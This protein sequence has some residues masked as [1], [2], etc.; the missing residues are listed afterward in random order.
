[1]IH[2]WLL[3]QKNSNQENK[4]FFRLKTAGILTIRKNY[5]K[6][7]ILVIDIHTNPKY[8]ILCYL[9]FLRVGI[10][11]VI[12]LQC[13]SRIYNNNKGDLCFKKHNVVALKNITNV[14]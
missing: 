10:K 11:K 3:R 1:M 9:D 5:K 14:L 8:H 4:F 12:V 6:C 2:I 13:S 7:D